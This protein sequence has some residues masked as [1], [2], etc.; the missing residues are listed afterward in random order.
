M[1]QWESN[2]SPI[3]LPEEILEKVRK[4]NFQKDNDY[5]F[6]RISDSY[7]FSFSRV[8]M[9]HKKINKNK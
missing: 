8:T 5:R 7:D 9:K 2:A 1:T 6:G 3:G 4:N